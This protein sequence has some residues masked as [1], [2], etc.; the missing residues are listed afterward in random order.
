MTVALSQIVHIYIYGNVTRKP[1]YS[2]LKHTKIS[3]FVFFYKIR[4]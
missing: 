3:S 4:E 1:M 2:Y